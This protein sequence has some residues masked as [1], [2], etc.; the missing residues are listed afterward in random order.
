MIE[1]KKS[2]CQILN[3]DRIVGTGFFIGT[4]RIITAA[5][6]IDNCS[7]VQVCFNESSD[8]PY[9]YNCVLQKQQ[10]DADLCILLI[11]ESQHDL[12][13]Q[14]LKITLKP[15][16]INSTYLSYGYPGENQGNMAYISGN[17]INAH[18]GST[19]T[20]YTADLEVL[21]GRLDNYE[22]FSGAPVVVKNEVVGICTYQCSNQ[23]RMVE[24]CKK[25][26]TL[27][28][29]LGLDSR[30]EKKYISNVPENSKNKNYIPR[31]YL[32]NEVINHVRNKNDS[33][34]LVIRGCSGMGKTTWVEQLENTQE[35][36]LLGKYYI[37]KKEDTL[38]VIYRKSEE[39]LYDWF[40]MM[41]NQFSSDRLEAIQSNNY[42]ARLKNV[43]KIAVQ[44]DKFLEKIN[45]H[46]LICIDG[47]DEFSNDDMRVFELFCSY[48][49][50]YQG[51]RMHVVLTLNN[52]KIL[53]LSVQ[54]KISEGNILDMELFGSNPIRT[55]LLE[56]LQIE[57]AEKYV[58]QLAE[59]SEGH[60]LYLHYII[61]SVNHCVKSGDIST[62]IEEF[63]AYGGDIRKYYSYKW[64]EIKK[65]ENSI[66][67]VAYL[68]RSRRTLEKQILLQMVPASEGIAFDVALDNMNGLLIQDKGLGFFHSSF[69]G[70]VCDQTEYLEEEIQHVM[71]AYCL[72]HQD[73]EYGVTQL[74]YHLANGNEEDKRKC[75]TLCNQK[76]MDKCGKFNGGPEMM[77]HDMQI[78]LRLCCDSG[79]FAQLIDKLLLMQRAQVRYDEMFVRFA[80]D[81]AMAE[82]ERNYPEKALEYLYRY[83]TCIV[84]DDELLSCL[85]KMVTKKQWNCAYEIVYRMETEIQ[86]FIQGEEAIS[87]G[88]ICTM[89]RGYQIVALAG[90]E[91]YYNKM[92]L[93]QKIIFSQELDSESAAMV[94]QASCDY[95][96]WKNGVFATAEKLKE[97]G[98]SVNQEIYNNWV[99]SV[100]G[101]A[102]LESI[103]EEKSKSWKSVLGEIK[104]HSLDY[105][106]DAHIMEIFVDVCM[107]TRE[108]ATLLRQ[109][110]IEQ[111]SG[112]ENTSLRKRNGVDVD[113]KKFRNMYIANRN[114]AYLNVNKQE[115][116]N[117]VR[118]VWKINWED[119]LTQLVCCIGSYYGLGLARSDKDDV[120]E[121]KQI[122]ENELFTFDERTEFKNAYHI[123]ETVMEYL[124]PLIAMYFIVLYPEEKDWFINFVRVKSEDQFGVYYESYFRIMFHIIRTFQQQAVGE[125][126]IG[127]LK[128]TFGDIVLKVS[129]R[130]E[131]TRLLLIIVK[132]F[133]RSGCEELAETA[134]EEMLKGSMGP[135]W[136][137]EAQYSLL[138]QCI[139]NMDKDDINEDIVRQS[140]ALLDAASG[141]M[142]FE[143][144]IR[145]SKESLIEEL[146]K[147][148]K[149][150][151][152]IQCMKIQLLPED[153]QA[154]IMSNY[155]PTDQK[156]HVIGNY[157]VANCIFPQR[158]MAHIL[159]DYKIPEGFKW[160]FSEIFLLVE[161]RNFHKYIGIQAA[162]LTNSGK[163]K[164]KYY[165]RILN[166]LLCDA[167]KYYFQ[168]LL[169]LYQNSLSDDDFQVILELVEEH[170]ETVDIQQLSM[171]REKKTVT[172]QFNNQ[173]EDEN[174]EEERDEF[175]LPGTWGKQVALKKAEEI[176]K[177][178]EIEEKK[179]N[180]LKAKSMCID[181]INIEENGGWP[182][183]NHGSDQYIDCSLE[184]LITLSVN[185]QEYMGLL[186]NAIIA[187]KYSARWQVAE[188][189]LDLS[190]TLLTKDEK[191]ECY[192]TI[193]KHYNE[194]MKVPDGLI[195]RY[196]ELKDE[197]KTV[198]EACYELLLGYMVYPNHYISQ[199]SIEL[200][201][202]LH[203]NN[204][205][206]IPLLI[207]H[208]DSDNLDIAEICSSY[209][210][211]LSD[212]YNQTLMKVL[213][214]I[215]NL[216]ERISQNQWMIV[217]G[218][219][220]LVIQRYASRS[221]ILRECYKSISN[222]LI[223][224]PSDRNIGISSGDMKNMLN[225]NQ[226][227]HCM[228]KSQFQKICSLA[229][230]KY[231]FCDE[232]EQKKFNQYTERICAG[233]HNNT[234]EQLLWRGKWYYYMN[235][236]QYDINNE[237][238]LLE[239][240]N[241]L[242]RVNWSFPLS[243]ACNAHMKKY[244]YDLKKLL[245]ENDSSRFASI[246]GER[247]RILGYQGIMLGKDDVE[248]VSIRT[249]LMTK[250]I[251]DEEMIKVIFG[252]P[253][254][255]IS[256]Y[257]FEST[258]L[259]NSKAKEITIPWYPGSIIG[260]NVASKVLNPAVLPEI[261]SSV[262][263]VKEG[264]FIGDREWEKEQSGRPSFL[265][266]Y[267]S[268]DTSKVRY[269]NEQKLIAC[270]RYEKNAIKKGALVDFDTYHVTY[271]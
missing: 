141:E 42:E 168:D 211:K 14:E 235:T 220:F 26:R 217:R 5:H 101:A 178:V 216:D 157:R 188:R 2:I 7:E 149:Y 231:G 212:K 88:K 139:R 228:E 124:I 164:K 77:M 19:D 192:E 180:I 174:N 254:F 61:E 201:S 62:F 81:L 241:A 46:G 172:E 111:F 89:L 177:Q 268:V 186:K 126:V 221:I 132:Y 84:S 256:N 85:E 120:D 227:Y 115:C 27:M 39:A 52:E 167:G 74:L 121:F 69:R 237:Y 137:K 23:L 10:P 9:V 138:E 202:W 262:N 79:Q 92:Q 97:N 242:R 66:K 194:M 131:R 45:K 200:F 145:T 245:T 95:N 72:E 80:G 263:A 33:Q 269:Q 51:K 166:I 76:W 226:T 255:S 3:Q 224:R 105:T 41:G 1:L 116:V 239:I 96:L 193:I 243:E 267:G 4:G 67:L 204:D 113:Y 38:P 128:K 176:W 90:N 259:Y 71:A 252:E 13:L 198:L 117:F 60:A 195:E 151:M 208:C 215:E 218:N 163:Q 112:K 12:Q 31:H 6:V 270:I 155:E 161:R 169:E 159:E 238:D 16:A 247:E 129:N 196:C 114:H 98:L 250:K 29:A 83:H 48:F 136:Y 233:F 173:P 179:G 146:W 165:D 34:I 44:L 209:C 133:I 36:F 206:L 28:E 30:E 57:D 24:F 58:D 199:K 258:V 130:Y 251:S 143:R 197:D 189:L 158:M 108:N 135:S 207:K 142:T 187:P 162:I 205:D 230:M 109:E 191:K 17:I 65:N 107:S 171:E 147:K 264:V 170:E 68:A 106:C 104:N 25:E 103:T 175:I 266:V 134:Y 100:I 37:N 219:M 55:Y 125:A 156:K 140:M 150:C 18:D 127:I 99:L 214:K 87:V 152:A 11:D 260:F 75:I 35:L 40:C 144:Y 20:E 213:E 110:D 160:A 225:I 102:N 249:F 148:E 78:V 184:K 86:K 253:V 15:A 232:T 234:L 21:N 22:G 32:Q 223:K 122:L 229:E 271:F 203:E 64:N 181:I 236:S 94:M 153:W 8:K 118:N 183:W 49:S 50:A 63:P 47:L 56:E 93:F 190:A 59:K 248:T 54:D 53:P 154:E 257:P 222:T 119:G 91:Y 261:V 82:I 210:L 185:P 246:F 123:P 240:L 73:N 182:I 70:Y 265:G 43:I 244:F